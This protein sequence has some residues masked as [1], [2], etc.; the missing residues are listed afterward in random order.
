MAT[1]L[2]TVLYIADQ[3]GLGTRLSYRRMFGEYALYL[4]TKVVALV[5]DD[6]L[7]LKPTDEGRILLGNPREVPAYPGSR[8]YFLLEEELESPALLRNAFEVTEAALPLPKP[9]SKSRAGIATKRHN[10]LS[11][12]DG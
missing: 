5:C 2:K 8:N 9:K 7:F 12:S 3:S 6:R 4:N 11:R 10:L 1:Q